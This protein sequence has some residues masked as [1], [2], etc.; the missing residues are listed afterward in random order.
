MSSN[1]SERIREVLRHYIDAGTSLAKMNPKEIEAAV[2]ELFDREHPTREKIED[3]LEELRARSRRGVDTLLDFVRA[4]VRR[5]VEVVSQ[6]RREELADLFE[7]GLGAFE[8]F[9][10]APRHSRPRDES[11]E[12][13]TSEP[14]SAPV[15]GQSRKA[16]SAPPSRRAK[17]AGTKQAAKS[18]GPRKRAGSSTSAGTAAK[19][20]AKKKPAPRPVKR[21]TGAARRSPGEGASAEG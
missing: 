21:A 2:R 4:E 5:E 19:A 11:G 9:I 3:S 1:G 13:E 14:E 18:A 7:R 10:S 8:D 16:A 15:S 12:S 17:P 20:A 6:R